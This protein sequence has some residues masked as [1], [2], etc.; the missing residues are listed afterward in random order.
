VVDHIDLIAGSVTGKIS[1]TKSDGNPHPAYSQIDADAKVIARFTSLDWE[2]G[3]DGWTVIQHHL[4]VTKD[5][6]FRIRGTN[7][8]LGGGQLDPLSGDPL[9]D[10][11]GVNNAAAAWV[12]LWFY[13]NPI[14]VKAIGS[15]K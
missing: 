2:V 13:S 4:Q 6:Y 10:A 14:F 9:P 7:Q 1:P 3:E 5:M 8:S 11:L 12:N 15:N